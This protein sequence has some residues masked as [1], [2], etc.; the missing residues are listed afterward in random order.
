VVPLAR[1]RRVIHVVPE[2]AEL[3]ERKDF[4]DFPATLDS[5]LAERLA[6]QYFLNVVCP[7]DV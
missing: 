4:G 6:M 7:W 1:V 3:T 5:Q 2:L